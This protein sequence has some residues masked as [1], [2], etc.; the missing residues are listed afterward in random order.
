MKTWF[1]LLA[2]SHPCF[3][4]DHVFYVR[5]LRDNPVPNLA[6]AP[7]GGNQIRTDVN[8]KV[9]LV[10][11]K[12]PGSLV[13]LNI[14]DSEYRWISPYDGRLAV[15]SDKVFIQ[16]LIV[17]KRQEADIITSRVGIEALM[18]KTLDEMQP[19]RQGQEV[20]VQTA[21]RRVAE[22]WDLPLADIERA[23]R[24]FDTDDIYQQGLKKLLENKN[25]EAESLLTEVDQMRTTTLVE[26]KRNLG[27]SQYLQGKYAEA[28]VSYRLAYKLRPADRKLRN[29]M[30]KAMLRSADYQTLEPLLRKAIAEDEVTI[31]NS[32][33]IAVS[34]I[35]MAVLLVNTNR[36]QRGRNSFP[37]GTCH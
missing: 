21:L 7:E 26:V 9:I 25:S 8:G 37:E 20:D 23:I 31:G 35:T 12:V 14:K 2:F 13:S 33:S 4:G 34:L 28:A 29:S 24:D 17:A 19:K 15:S 22:H 32:A 27:L 18:K 11:N 10:I 36:K 5:D 1:F 16:R 30:F 6:L 3:S